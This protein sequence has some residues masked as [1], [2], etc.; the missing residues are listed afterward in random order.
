[1]F[2]VDNTRGSETISVGK[3]LLNELFVDYQ[4]G[5]TTPTSNFSV[6]YWLTR[7]VRLTGSY[8]RALPD[9]TNSTPAATPSGIRVGLKVRKEF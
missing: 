5:L 4:Q 8:S 7:T 1:M 9:A 2:D 6:E 3:Y